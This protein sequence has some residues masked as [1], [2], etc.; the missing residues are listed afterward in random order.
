MKHR[1]VP[2]AL[3]SSWKSNAMAD[4]APTRSNRPR[5]LLEQQRNFSSIIRVKQR[6]LRVIIGIAQI[7]T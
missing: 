3:G 5:F 2:T 1:R 7:S 6:T 4:E